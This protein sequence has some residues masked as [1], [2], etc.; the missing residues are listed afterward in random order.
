MR[1]ETF[2]TTQNLT[3]QNSF[4]VIDSQKEVELE[5]TVGIHED[6]NTGWFEMYDLKTGGEKWYCEGGLW[7][8]DK[9]ITDYDGVFSLPKCVEEKLNE[10]GYDTE[11]VGG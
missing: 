11:E 6:G 9:T 1:Q 5:V 10:W 3:R 2:K 8:D 7:I 4:G